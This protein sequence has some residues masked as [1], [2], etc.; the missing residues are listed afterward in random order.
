MSKLSNKLMLSCRKATELIEKKNHFSLK[1]LEKVQLYAHT[2]MCNSCKSFQKESVHM[3][4]FLEHHIKTQN[5]NTDSSS[6]KL[7][8][9]FKDLI[10][11]K[12]ENK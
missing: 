3:E 4:T 11:Y 1:P 5:R 12:L 9:D 7:S 2:K 10:I 8:E 6:I